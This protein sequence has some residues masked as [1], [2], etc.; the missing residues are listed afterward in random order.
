MSVEAE[1]R[2]RLAALEP[3]S[4]E[5]EDQSAQHAGHSG[6]RP[7]GGTH[8][9]LRLVSR[10]FSGVSGVASAQGIQSR[11]EPHRRR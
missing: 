5:L 2:A 6:A 8:W 7:G 4:L 1:M 9:Q 10:K 3:V 11:C